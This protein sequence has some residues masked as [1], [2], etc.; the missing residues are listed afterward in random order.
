M[1]GLDCDEMNILWQNDLR[2]LT[3][4]L[5]EDAKSTNFCKK[6]SFD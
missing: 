5:D 4:F 6:K 1:Y 3:F 2:L